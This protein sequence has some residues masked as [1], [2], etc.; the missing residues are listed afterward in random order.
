MQRNL[1]VPRE[2]ESTMVGAWWL[3]PPPLSAPW[4]QPSPSAKGYHPGYWQECGTLVSVL[5]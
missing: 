4:P 3:K 1:Q 5:R 2:M